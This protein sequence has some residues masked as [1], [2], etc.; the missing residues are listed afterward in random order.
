MMTRDGKESVEDRI[1]ESYQG[2]IWEASQEI[3]ERKKKQAETQD[4]I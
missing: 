3:H 2:G 4:D 1:V